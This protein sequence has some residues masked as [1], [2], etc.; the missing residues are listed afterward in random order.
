MIVETIDELSTE[1]WIETFP[2]KYLKIIAKELEMFV[3]LKLSEFRNGFYAGRDAAGCK[4]EVIDIEA[5]RE[6]RTTFSIEQYFTYR[7]IILNEKIRGPIENCDN[8]FLKDF[9]E[10]FRVAY[11]ITAQLLNNHFGDMKPEPYTLS[12]DLF[13][14]VQ[15]PEEFEKLIKV[16]VLDA[17]ALI[18]HFDFNHT[19]FGELK[20]LLV[21]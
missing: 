13:G 17:N 3:Y 16:F 1:E 7:E 21:F 10:A 4:T 2:P 20:V 8:N 15:E 6:L 12:V 11:D 14:P 9:D 18:Y 19:V 5:I